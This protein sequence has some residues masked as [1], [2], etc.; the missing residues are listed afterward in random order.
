M[1]TWLVETDKAFFQL[2]NS[3]WNNAFF[4]FLLPYLRSKTFWIPLYLLIATL[5][6]YKY[7]WNALYMFLL[8]GL[9]VLICDQIS[10]ELI[11]KTVERL[12]PCNDPDMQAQLRL[13]VP[14][15]GG[16][17]FTSSHATN[18]FALAYLFFQLLRPLL[19]VN[20]KKWPYILAFSCFLWASSIAYSQVYVGVHYPLDITAGACLGTLVAALTFL[21]YK[22]LF[23]KYLKKIV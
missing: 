17:S 20:N 16:F 14:C 22:I 7:K 8:I 11:K 9:T 5:L 13:L 6:L 23:N 19:P 4:D 2:I 18:H 12:R 3:S 10:S 15:G 1:L 21:C